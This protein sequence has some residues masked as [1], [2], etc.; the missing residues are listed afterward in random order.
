MCKMVSAFGCAELA[1]FFCHKKGP[2]RRSAQYAGREA[3]WY[4]TVK[5]PFL[6]NPFVVPEF[7]FWHDMSTSFPQVTSK[8]MHGSAICSNNNSNPIISLKYQ[9]FIPKAKM[10]EMY[11]QMCEKG[12]KSS[13]YLMLYNTR[14]SLQ[15]SLVDVQYNNIRL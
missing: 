13:T 7:R 6:P 12:Q 2:Q 1:V 3:A 15:L 4:A 8:R 5:G 11:P 10:Y 9:L 14:S